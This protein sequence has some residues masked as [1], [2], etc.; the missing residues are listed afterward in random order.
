MVDDN[1]NPNINTY[2]SLYTSSF[3]LSTTD[4]SQAN[5]I[6]GLTFHFYGNQKLNFH[7]SSFETCDH[8]AL[9]SVDCSSRDSWRWKGQYRRLQS[10]Y[11][12]L[13][14]GRVR[15]QILLAAIYYCWHW[16]C[17]LPCWHLNSHCQTP[18]FY[19]QRKKGPGPEPD[20]MA[21]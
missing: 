2:S 11:C 17:Q 20:A 21:F 7:T 9:S 4:D 1:Q 3:Q 16:H 18:C 13:I 14:W 10:L 5:R 12:L 8:V 15:E 19:P 6:G